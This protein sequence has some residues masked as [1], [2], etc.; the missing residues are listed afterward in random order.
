M[1]GKTPTKK[2]L[3][4]SSAFLIASIGALIYVTYSW[5]TSQRQLSTTTWIKT[6]VVLTIGSG[7]N[8]D[9]KYLDMGDI[10]VETTNYK[11][12]VI[13]VYGTPVDSYSLQLAYTTN[14][15]FHYEIYRAD[16]TDSAENSVES[17]YTDVKGNL[18]TEY[19][20]KVSVDPVITGKTISEILADNDTVASHQSH[21]MSY[22]DENGQNPVSK[23]KIQSS[24]EPLYWLAEENDTNILQPQN[25]VSTDDGTEAFLDYFIIHVSWDSEEVVNDKETDIVY[26]T[27]SR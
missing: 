10:D 13:C 15:A 5:I 19:F 11:D 1:T 7:N 12:Y 25:I 17:T 16:E 24:A 3:I 9:I 20:S 23:D 14:I 4:I 18:Q 2:M 6:P 27:V 22:G 21:T 8:H 26:L